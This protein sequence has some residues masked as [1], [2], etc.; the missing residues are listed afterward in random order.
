MVRLR[1]SHY[2]LDLGLRMLACAAARRAIGTRKGEQETYVSPILW[3]NSTDEGS[4]PCL[5]ADTAVHVGTNGFTLFHGHLHQRAHALLIESCKRIGLVNLI[6][7]ICV[8]EFSGV[9]T[10]EAERHLSKIV[11]T[12]AEELG[13]GRQFH[14]P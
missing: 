11:G 9:V 10:A 6:G 14:L 12:E 8:K 5:S 13:L 1:T 2:Y 4:P 7:V 3:Q